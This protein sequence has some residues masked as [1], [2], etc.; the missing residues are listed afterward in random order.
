MARGRLGATIPMMSYESWIVIGTIAGAL[1]LFASERVRPDV[2]ALLV[3][4]TLTLTG[5]IE[6]LDAFAGFSSPAVITVAAMFVLSAATVQ[7]GLP[8]LIANAIARLGGTR[9]PLVATALVL[10]VGALSAFLNNIAATVILLPAAV[11]LARAARTSASKLLIPVSFGS[12]LGGLLT[13][14]GTP[15]NLLVS[16]ALAAAG[17]APFQMFDFAPTGL[18]VLGIGLVYL[19]TVGQRLLPAREGAGLAQEVKQTREFT[20]EV[21]VPARSPA[22]GRTLESLAWTRRYG[23][24]VTDTI[25]S[26]RQ[27]RYPAAADTLQAGDVVLLAGERDDIVRAVE[28]QALEF[29]AEQRARRT[30]D[31]DEE[32]RIVEL[33]VG[34]RFGPRRRTVMGMSFRWRYGGLVLGVWRQGQRIRTPIA[35]IVV[36]PGDVLLVRMPAARMDGLARSDDFILLTQRPRAFAPRPRMIVPVA[37]L[38]LVVTLAASGLAHISVAAALGVLLV[39]AARAISYDRLYAAVEWRTLVMIGSLIPLGTA[40]STTGLAADLAELVS[41]T[42]R[43]LGPLAVLAGVYLVTTVVTQIM[44]NAAAVVLVAPIALGIAANLGISPHATLMLVA[45]SASTAFLTPIGHQANVLVYNT[46][47][48]RFVDFLRVGA[49]LTILILVAS[50]FVVPIVW[51]L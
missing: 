9:I 39:L 45:I 49:P 47:G 11:A 3:P 26:G 7:A 51:P 43:G 25:R 20:A 42:L 37:V 41:S 29:A 23:V 28:E 8:E 2:V 50:L 14:T 32:A 33:V 22:A 27:N 31:E 17:H 36:Q 19:A 34:P 5:V 15:P 30:L 12:L 40:M 24:T 18:A 35:Q 46:G 16:D 4:V 44:S 48:Y 6:P 1:A 10:A 13:L 21:T 38:A